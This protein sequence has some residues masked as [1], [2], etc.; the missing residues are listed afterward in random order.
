MKNNAVLDEG[1]EVKANLIGIQIKSDINSK[2]IMA[3]FSAMYQKLRE[4]LQA[5]GP[6]KNLWISESICMRTF[7]PP[8]FISLP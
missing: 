6:S 1:S 2:T 5:K 4:F 8:S 3:S 7:F